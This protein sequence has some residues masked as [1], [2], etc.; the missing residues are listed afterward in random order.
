MDGVQKS[1][2]ATIVFEMLVFWK[3]S[4]AKIIRISTSD[5]IVNFGCYN[6]SLE[7][8]ILNLPSFV[9]ALILKPNTFVP[10]SISDRSRPKDPLTNFENGAS[11][12]MPSNLVPPCIYIKLP[13][14]SD[15]FLTEKNSKSEAQLPRPTHSQSYMDIPKNSVPSLLQNSVELL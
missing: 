6:E 9:V 8:S 14:L 2:R 15:T 11:V 1:K 7:V 12:S 13:Q 4:S 5:I 10:G 3:A